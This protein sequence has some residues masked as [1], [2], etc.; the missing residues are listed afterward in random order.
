MVIN[1][2]KNRPITL[3]LDSR[4]RISWSFRL[5]GNG[6]PSNWLSMDMF[7]MYPREFQ[8][9]NPKITANMTSKMYAIG[10]VK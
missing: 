2:M 10:E 7:T 9:K 5:R 1:R 4:G 6:S 8:K 3:M